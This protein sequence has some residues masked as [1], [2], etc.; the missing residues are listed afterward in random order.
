VV[1]VVDIFVVSNV[2]ILVTVGGKFAIHI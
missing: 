1:D 2:I